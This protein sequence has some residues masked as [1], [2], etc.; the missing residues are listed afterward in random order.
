MKGLLGKEIPAFLNAGAGARIPA[1]ATREQA[2]NT[3]SEVRD[4]KDRRRIKKTG[5]TEYFGVRVT[6]GFKKR[7]VRLQGELSAQRQAKKSV[8][9]GELLEVMADSYELLGEVGEE[10][11]AMLEKIA[12]KM[13][14]SDDE[15]VQTLV[16]A[17]A[18]ELGL[19]DA[20]KGRR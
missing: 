6:E 15:V 14:I 11:R 8:T 19:V 16:A 9:L 20:R 7:C 4:R 17:K 2:S 3:L 10:E 13:K 5:R 1:P 18:E 12:G